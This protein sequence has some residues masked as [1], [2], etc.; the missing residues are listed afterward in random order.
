MR[1]RS[2]SP[3]R[4]SPELAAA[5]RRAAAEAVAVGLELV[6]E[7]SERRAVAEAEADDVERDTGER[8]EA[9]LAASAFDSFLHAD[10]RR[11]QAASAFDVP[12]AVE[13]GHG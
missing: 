9:R 2:V 1:R 4:E 11:Q 5:K 7:P 3:Q 6:D 13:L 12:D 8:A 10:E